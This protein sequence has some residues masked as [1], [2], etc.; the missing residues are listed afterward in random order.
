[1]NQRSF[2]GPSN[3]LLSILLGCFLLSVGA[4]WLLHG[5]YQFAITDWSLSWHY[6]AAVDWDAARLFWRGISPYSYEGLELIG[7][8]HTG[9]GHPPTTAFWFLP[10]AQFDEHT[11]A[12]VLGL[13]NFGMLLSLVAIAVFTLRYPLPWL[14]TLVVF[15]Y[16]Q[17]S[18]VTFDHN[19]IVQLSVA[20]A[21]GT[22][23]AWRFLRARRDLAGGAA[24]G[25]VCT[26]KPFPGAIGLLL[27]LTGRFRALAAA[28]VAFLGVAALMTWRFGTDS[29]S[30]FAEQQRG[31]A[32]YWM[33]SIRN[34]SLQGVL[35]RMLRERCGWPELEEG[36]LKLITLG[37][38]ALLLVFCTWVA[39]RALRRRP[40]ASTFD[41]AYA[42][43]TVLATF[44]NPWVWEHYVFVLVLPVLVAA[45]TLGEH[46]VAAWRAWSAG[47]ISH[48]VQLRTT[49]LTG[50]GFVPLL[51]MPHWSQV[52]FNTNRL[53]TRHYCDYQTTPEIKAWLL[54]NARYL[55]LTSWLPWALT[56][57]ILAAL[58][59]VYG[60]RGP[61][62]LPQEPEAG[63][64]S[65]AP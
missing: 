3:R 8:A 36:R 46:L 42:L 58:L 6:D 43:F 55:E 37:S 15:G 54:H 7:V 52:N 27:L 63:S 25:L 13:L 59:L 22:V 4:R 35:R 9:F 29:W 41:L 65:L 30:L 17:D 40:G 31:I 64:A 32:R 33:D 62:P 5:L 47:S 34:A 12:H 19:Q 56:L 28:A 49:L 51:A 24:L 50:A 20:I 45:R 11:M 2:A 48:G 60:R 26:L 1:M 16:L 44:I 38:C 61:R 18:T 53:A 10:L 23:L 57:T 39:L 21:F 14:T